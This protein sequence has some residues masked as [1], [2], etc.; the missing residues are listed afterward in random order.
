M[1]PLEEAPNLGKVMAQK[2]KS[3]GINTLEELKMIGAEQAFMRTRA[4]DPG[5]CINS[6]MALEEA[7]QGMRWHDLPPERKEELKAFK[8]ML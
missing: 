3:V 4:V 6:L 7:I 5:A 8:K 1:T 2:L